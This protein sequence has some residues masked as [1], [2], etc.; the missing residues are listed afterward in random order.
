M[1]NNK[2]RFCYTIINVVINHAGIK[3]VME[4]SMEK[5]VV[6]KERYTSDQEKFNS[7]TQSKKVEN[8][9]QTHNTRKEGIGPI[10]NKR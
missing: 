5:N 7:V 9:N 1:G 3:M 8:Q 2:K 6:E 10:N 4:V